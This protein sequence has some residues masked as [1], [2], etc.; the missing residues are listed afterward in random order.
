MLLH[1][2]E[3]AVRWV[4][5]VSSSNYLDRFIKSHKHS[6]Y[7][8]LFTPGYEEPNGGKYLCK[9]NTFND[10]VD[11]ARFLVEEW[12]TPDKL[13]CEGRSA[14]GLLIGASIN[15][16]PELFKCAI[17]GVPFVDVSVTMTDSTIPLTSGE[18]V[19]WGNVS[20][21]TSPYTCLLFLLS[22]LTHYLP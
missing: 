8:M 22:S 16:A 7:S 9:K 21:I 19:E 20:I 2:F 3:V 1:T 12:T 13:S 4:D 5:N 14:G 18:W 6:Q 10:F 15:Q 11:V 17:L